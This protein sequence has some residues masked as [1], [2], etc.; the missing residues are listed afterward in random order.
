MLC[1]SL[2]F[3]VKERHMND[4]TLVMWYLN[5]TRQV[6]VLMMFLVSP[7]HFFIPILF[8]HLAGKVH[9]VIW[10]THSVTCCHVV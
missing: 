10:L 4:T 9:T 3:T 7:M 6:M 1:S 8:C 2:S 5:D